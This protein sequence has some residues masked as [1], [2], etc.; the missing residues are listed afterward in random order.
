MAESGRIW[1]S[2]RSFPRSLRAK[3]APTTLGSLRARLRRIAR[4]HLEQQRREHARW[5]TEE[6]S[7]TH[8]RLARLGILRPLPPDTLPAVELSASEPERYPLY[9]HERMVRDLYRLWEYFH[10]PSVPRL[11]A[12]KDA[13]WRLVAAIQRTLGGCMPAHEELTSFLR[14]LWERYQAK[15]RRRALGPPDDYIPNWRSPPPRPWVPR[16]PRASDG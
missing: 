6:Q 14:D 9:P 10:Q 16:P 3:L 4:A 7:R 15:A 13:S 2:S 1:H 5:L 11:F 8:R 12:R